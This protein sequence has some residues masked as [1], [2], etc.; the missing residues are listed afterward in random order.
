[1]KIIT[2]AFDIDGVICKTINSDYKNSIPDT[3]AIKKINSLHDKGH[4]IIIF[5]ARFM[6]RTNND[7]K[8]AYEIGYDFTLKQLRGWKVKFDK[9][10]MGKPSYDIFVD[11]RAYNFNEDWISKI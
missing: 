3:K 1:M 8:Q 6:G 11:D 2:Y 9:L 10:L 5:T 7:F 4:K